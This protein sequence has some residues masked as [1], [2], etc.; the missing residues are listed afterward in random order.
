[1]DTLRHRVE[2]NSAL[3]NALLSM[4]STDC[5][6]LQRTGN[7]SPRKYYV[8]S[9]MRKGPEEPQGD[10]NESVFTFSDWSPPYLFSQAASVLRSIKKVADTENEGEDSDEADCEN[11]EPRCDRDDPMELYADAIVAKAESITFARIAAGVSYE[12]IP[13]LMSSAMSEARVMRTP[14]KR[15]LGMKMA[16]VVGALSEVGSRVMSRYSSGVQYLV[17]SI[18]GLLLMSIIVGMLTLVSSVVFDIPSRRGIFATGGDMGRDL[19]EPAT[20]SRY[21]PLDFVK[22]SDATA[23]WLRSYDAVGAFRSGFFGTESTDNSNDNKGGSTGGSKRLSGVHTPDVFFPEDLQKDMRRFANAGG[24]KS[25][26][27]WQ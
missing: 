9:M 1:M 8:E 19:A 22:G 13:H 27:E 4:I 12:C 17:V 20:S 14:K 24:R 7:A 3:S 18:F 11:S 10:E 5:D 21:A 16:A 15:T 6:D 23:R 26:W 2:V 25:K